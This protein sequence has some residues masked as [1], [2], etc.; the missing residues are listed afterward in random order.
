MFQIHQRRW[1]PAA[2][3][4]SFCCDYITFSGSFFFPLLTLLFVVVCFKENNVNAAKTPK[5]SHFVQVCYSLSKSITLN[6]LHLRTNCDFWNWFCHFVLSYMGRDEIHVMSSCRL[7]RK[8]MGCNWRLQIKLVNSHSVTIFVHFFPLHK[9]SGDGFCYTSNQLPCKFV[10]IFTFKVIVRDL[11]FLHYR[12]LLVITGTTQ[13]DR[14]L[15][16]D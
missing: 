6:L 13:G 10:F 14:V 5:K 4:C 1:R 15:A 16:T 8:T 3:C 9:F 2:S 12:P 7:L 11:N